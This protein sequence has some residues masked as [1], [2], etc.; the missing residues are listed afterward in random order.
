MRSHSAA[1]VVEAWAG[2]S[3]WDQIV[4][5]CNLDDGDIARL[6]NRQVMSGMQCAEAQCHRATVIKLT[7]SLARHQSLTFAQRPPL[8]L[9][10]CVAV[11]LGS[12]R[13]GL[14]CNAQL[15]CTLSC[16]IINAGPWTC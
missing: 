3:T 15:C 4:M 11:L 2:G 1:G 8:N 5:D 13:A 12:M 14:H 10:E 9:Q 16:G 6:L 7:S